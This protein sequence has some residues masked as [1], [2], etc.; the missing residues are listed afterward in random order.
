MHGEG[1]RGPGHQNEP[2]SASQAGPQTR[3]LASS[4]NTVDKG[5]LSIVSATLHLLYWSRT[6]ASLAACVERA[7]A[8]PSG[9]GRD[10]EDLRRAAPLFT[11]AWLFDVLPRALGLDQP[12]LHN[13][14]GDEVVFHEVT[15]P[16][17]PTASPE[18]VALRMG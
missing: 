17:T 9:R 8:T 12:T 16:P 7:D 14:E 2:K 5:S 4:S 11:M 18:E 3:F 6:R 10:D 1:R 13:S 15:F